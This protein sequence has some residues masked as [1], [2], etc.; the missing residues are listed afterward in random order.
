LIVSPLQLAIDSLGRAVASFHPK[1]QPLMLRANY[2]R[3]LAASCFL[4]FMLGAVE[5]GVVGVLAKAFF[6]AEV[7]QRALN[8][9]VAVLAGA[10]AFANI[11][12]FLWAA[13]SHGRHKIRMLV[14]LQVAAAGCVMA[15]AFA[16]RNLAGLLLFTASV[17]GARMCWSG[18]VT[19]R[20]TVWRANYPRHA[21]AS[22]AGKLATVQAIAMTLAGMGIG[23]AMRA[24][25]EAFRLLYPV[26]AVS[27]FAGAWIYSALRL[28][29]HRALLRA[30]SAD[31]RF[32]GS[33]VSPLQ[34][35]QVLLADARFRRYMTCM[36]VFGAGNL[37]VV[38][39]LVIM[40]KDRF[41]LDPF[42]SVMIAS[43]IPTLLMPVSIPV[44]SRLLDRVHVVRF[45]AIHSWAFAASTAML[46]AGAVTLHVELLWAGAILKGVAFGG[47][48]LGWNLGHHDFAPAQRASQYM[49]VHVT[50][51]GIRGLLAPMIAVSLYE[52]LEWL[53]PGAG[54]WTLALC[55]GLNLT[56]AVWF[57]LMRRTLSGPGCRGQFQDGPPVHPPAAA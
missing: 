35:R 42:S 32:Q 52:A 15:I 41:G 17:V 6:A 39:P 55:L 9:A 27:G 30:E 5:G 19:V 54:A 43:A 22:L 44:W 46:L 49:G 29:G 8:L 33:R 23:V 53:R 31:D 1:T 26:A 10:P 40:L 36:F 18:V 48:V 57:V 16:P 56:G 37:M 3:E 12:S 11:I 45:R 21:R 25:D 2:A 7:P 4:P 24:N 38:A 13:L 20:S 14:A 28:R 47:G 50:L 34:L 51:T